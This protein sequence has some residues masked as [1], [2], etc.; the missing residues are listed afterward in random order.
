[1]SDKAL[2]LNNPTESVGL[3]RILGNHRDTSPTAELTF[4]NI[5]AQ[6]PSINI[7]S[8]IYRF[9]SPS[10]NHNLSDQD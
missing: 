3:I 4:R 10:E 2:E 8:E 9:I 1:V 5:L 6:D 7:K